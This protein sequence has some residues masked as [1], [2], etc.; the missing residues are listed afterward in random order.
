MMEVVDTGTG[1]EPALLSQIFEPYFTTKELGK[2]TG[3]GLSMVYGIINQSGGRIEVASE[4]GRGTTFK[5]HLPACY[6]TPQIALG[7]AASRA[8]DSAG[9]ET[10]FVVED[11]ASVRTVA[12]EIL[13]SNGYEVL[14]ASNGVEAL[15][16]IESFEGPID[17]LLTDVVMPQM[18]GTEL[19]ERLKTVRP[20]VRVLFMSGY[21]EESI[22]GARLGKSSGVLIQKPFSPRGLAQRVRDALDD[23]KGAAEVF[24]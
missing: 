11:E 15:H 8:G 19:A 23:E 7:E 20:G 6:E 10:I 24:P 12:C 2:G 1:V 5:I 18:K 3:L 13:R 21:N 22:L 16:N 17:L 4:V 9:H 14:E